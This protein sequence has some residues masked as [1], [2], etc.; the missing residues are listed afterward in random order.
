MRRHAASEL[1]IAS[2]NAAAVQPLDGGKILRLL[3]GQLTDPVSAD[4]AS[5]A[6]SLI[7]LFFMGMAGFYILLRSRGN[8]SLLALALWLAARVLMGEE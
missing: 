3:L 4:R 6:V 5:L 2:V 1:C 7:T 8:F